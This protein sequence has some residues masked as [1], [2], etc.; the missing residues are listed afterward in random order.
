VPTKQ[1]DVAWDADVAE[2]TASRSRLVSVSAHAPHIT[3]AHLLQHAQGNERVYWH[4]PNGPAF[5]ATG[6]A[7]ELFAWGAGRVNDIEEQARRLFVGAALPSNATAQTWPRLVGGFAFRED[8]VPDNTWAAFH[9]AHFVLPHIQFVQTDGP[10]GGWLTLNALV[11]EGES[12]N[13]AEASLQ[14]ALNARLAWLGTT[15]QRSS[16]L[17]ASEQ[18][19]L[20]RLPDVTYP[21]S[22]ER[23]SEMIEQALGKIA[24]GTL[25]KVVLS[26]VCELRGEQDLDVDAALDGLNE[27]YA[28]CYRFLFEPRPGHAFLGATPELLVRVNG[29]A[30]ETMALAGSQRRGRDAAED[31]ELERD[32]LNSAKDQH[33]HRLVIDELRT[34]LAPQVA[35]DGLRIGTTQSLKLR[36]IQHLFTPVQAQLVQAT[37]VLP[38][39]ARLHPTPALGGLPHEAA[40]HFIREAEPVTRGWYAAPV[41]WL[42][43]NLDGEFA[44]AI[45]S[46]VVQRERAWLYAGCGI[47]AGSDPQ[48]EWDETALKF[49]PMLRALRPS[50][51]APLPQGEGS[52]FSPLLRGE[53]PGVRG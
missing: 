49:K 27:E 42:D 18:Q 52:A 29:R 35:G 50:P 24:S 48:R 10:V 30:L 9:P 1:S 2:G 41:G 34:R 26:R 51:P 37:G 6:V 38:Q 16:G 36:N 8:F 5:A 47:V 14:E 45:R 15:L 4:S 20:E 33:E 22:F 23:W 25:K 12:V 39:V 43:V 19:P 31:V 53:G 46:A 17:F 28:D 44:V 21:L 32:L 40:H 7:A 11:G 13:D 3:T